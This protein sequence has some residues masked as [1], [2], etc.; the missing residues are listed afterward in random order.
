MW[1][2]HVMTCNSVVFVC[3]L[4]F[5]SL[6]C[7][8]FRLF[9]FFFHLLFEVSLSADFEIGFNS[10]L[11]KALWWPI[12][13]VS[14]FILF[15]DIHSTSFEFYIK[16]RYLVPIDSR[17]LKIKKILL[18]VRFSNEYKPEYFNEIKLTFYILLDVWMRVFSFFHLLYFLCT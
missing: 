18:P 2:S 12:C 4:Y 6:I 3:L 8:L 5:R 13:F 11:K 16:K 14:W 9:D 1:L 10:F 15:I 7:T 17:D